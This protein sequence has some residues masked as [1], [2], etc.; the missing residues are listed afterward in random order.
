MET[1][2]ETPSKG[3]KSRAKPYSRPGKSA[4][5]S[6]EEQ[7][8]DEE[9]AAR[10]AGGGE[11]GMGDTD[12]TTQRSVIIRNPYNNDRR[13]H[14]RGFKNTHHLVIQ[15]FKARGSCHTQNT[16]DARRQIYTVSPSWYFDTGELGMYMTDK[17]IEEI[18]RHT[19]PTLP[20]SPNMVK[21]KRVQGKISQFGIGAP[22]VA[23]T[24]DQAATN[25]M[26]SQAV[27]V[28]GNLHEKMLVKKGKVVLNSS[29]AG[30]PTVT[31]FSA[32][33]V[34]LDTGGN[35]TGFVNTNNWELIGKCRNATV[36]PTQT[37][38]G[39]IYFELTDEASDEAFQF[40]EQ[41]AVTPV[42]ISTTIA[43]TAN[44]PLAL[45]KKSPHAVLVD[46]TESQGVICEWNE[47]C[48]WMISK[49]NAIME[50]V[51]FGAA[52]MTLNIDHSETLTMTAGA[53]E[54]LPSTNKVVEKVDPTFNFYGSH[55]GK[56]GNYIDTAPG[57]DTINQW[58]TLPTFNI[59]MIPPPTKASAN[60][61]H[62]L[63]P[64]VL[65]TEI[66]IEIAFDGTYCLPLTEAT[67]SFSLVTGNPKFVNF[68]KRQQGSFKIHSSQTHAQKWGTNPVY[69][70]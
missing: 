16:N 53:N 2:P 36:I 1:P 66:D 49:P 50:S 55:I 46:M 60:S 70:N 13:M 29:A 41:V 8:V 5:A 65:E 10:E 28:S 51:G 37:A 40:Y 32:A 54:H 58:Q 26:V 31:S 69:F 35:V 19:S 59:H 4:Q 7:I 15:T 42:P 3:K 45:P 52:N 14:I 43:V 68:F 61:Q 17:L 63:M 39:S 23:G 6:V 64:L 20:I 48:D 44:V 47:D 25:S 56:N 9:L 18:K 11:A 22:F 57:K 30:I 67:N 33:E 21:V 24:A 34:Q 38:A 12:G 62:V 27:M